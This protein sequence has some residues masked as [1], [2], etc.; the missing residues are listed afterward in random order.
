[1]KES[2]IRIV[3]YSKIAKPH[4]NI[5]YGGDII[6]RSRVFL[7]ASGEYATFDSSAAVTSDGS[8]LE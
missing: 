2:E 1:M 3:D 7:Y 4:I 8:E 6:H 5:L